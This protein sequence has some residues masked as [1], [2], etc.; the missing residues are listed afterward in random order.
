MALGA[1]EILLTMDND[2]TKK[3][4]NLEL[5]KKVSKSITTPVIAGGIGEL[6][7]F[8]DGVRIGGASGLLAVSVFHYKKFT[9]K[10]V[11]NALLNDGIPVRI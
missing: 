1:G 5:T 2:G 10:D 6:S 11:K 8:I 7:H 9:I 3:G 4:F